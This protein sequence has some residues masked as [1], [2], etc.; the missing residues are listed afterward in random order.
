M[1]LDLGIQP[2]EEVVH[3]ALE[4]IDLTN[5]VVL[6]CH[7]GRL[8]R[9]PPAVLVVRL[10]PAHQSILVGVELPLLLRIPPPLVGQLLLLEGSSAVGLGLLLSLLL[11]GV[12]GADHGLGKIP[13][14]LPKFVAE[15]VRVW[16][17]DYMPSH[18]DR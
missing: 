5:A 14:A 16:R 8:F 9:L 4:E 6:G 1:L 3:R 12:L 11:E 7:Q 18:V 17:H 10:I 15:S 13:E 2:G